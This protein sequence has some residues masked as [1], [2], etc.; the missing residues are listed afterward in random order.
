[1]KFFI[2]C[3]ILLA[4]LAVSPSM[5][6]APAPM[7]AGGEEVYRAFV[8]PDGIQHV[9]IIGGSYFFRPSHIIVRANVPVEFEVS[10]ERGMIPHSLVINAPEA[11]IAI[12]EKLSTEAKPIRFTPTATGSYPFYCKNKL[13]FLKSHR[14]KGMEGTLEVVE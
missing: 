6:E 5:A 7:L 2:F 4:T 1:M 3:L 12:D 10:L 9:A 8:G 11:G 14:E 13:L